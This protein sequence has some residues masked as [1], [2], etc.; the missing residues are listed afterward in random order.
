MEKRRF[1]G[2]VMTAAMGLALAATAVGAAQVA[3]FPR[4]VVPAGAYAIQPVPLTAV[5]IADRFWTPRAETNRTVT[6]PHIMHENEITGRVDNFLK[7]AH[8]RDGE[9]QG[10]RYNDTDVYK[11]I[12]AAS[13]SLADHPNPALS[14]KLDE[15]IAIIGAAQ[16]HDGYLYTPRTID[17]K[18]PAPGAGPERWSWLL[19][20]HELYDQ[21]H[22]IEAA[23][24]HHAV[25]GKRNFLDIAIRS[26][27]L[28]ASTFGP[29]KRRDVPGHEEIEIALVK[30]YRATG[31]VKYLNLAKFFLT[32]RGHEHG[33]DKPVF[34][35][36]NRFF[37]YNDLSYRQDQ[38]PV[39][40]QTA[41][42]GHAVRATY[43]YSAMTDISAFFG[44]LYDDTL[45]AL[46]DDV[47]ER[48]MYVTGGLGAEAGTEAFG[49]PYDLPNHAYAE[50]CASVGGILWYHRMFLRDG[51][52]AHYDALERT[53][54]NGYLSGVSLAGNAFFY[55]NP[56]VSDGRQERSAYFD[57]ACCPAN[58]SRL[59]AE[60][61]GLVYAH[62]G[63]R[64]FVNLYI[65]SDADV[66]GDGLAL[67]LT[68]RTDYPWD[69]RVT[70]AVR[71]DAPAS[72]TLALRIPRWALPAAESESALYRLAPLPAGQ[73]PAAPS[74]MVNGSAVPLNLHNGYA[75]ISRTWRRGD[76]VTLTLPMPVRRVLA[77]AKV[78]EDAGK[79][80]VQRGPIVYALEGIDN[81]GAL[82]GVRLPLDAAASHAFRADLLNGVEVVTFHAGDRTIT[83]VPYYSWNNRGK[84]QMEFWIPN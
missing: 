31:H 58:L 26:A 42:V 20:S 11:I 28:I 44:G 25:P 56:L 39:Q 23:V 79:A 76:I 3:V 66:R 32:E 80:A 7:A 74:L 54:Y 55:Q 60:L 21:G 50:T 4:T 9:F 63:R 47:T 29:S 27:D 30:L 67:H 52:A 62:E 10:Q 81:G 72:A 22:M 34:P 77:N 19:T 41:A 61:P 75:E 37:M 17:P 48:K 33:V 71:P 65:G 43:L 68:Q 83:A 16:E 53:L 45:A 14:A 73:P 40:D 82:E 69:G 78:K 6:I 5:R 70:I 1:Q 13:W 64:V 2:R 38:T 49:G 35:Q 15:L 12:E 36:G 8:K 46:F 24:A 57:V 51:R 84:G 18:H 59:M